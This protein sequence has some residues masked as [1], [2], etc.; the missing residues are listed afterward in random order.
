M[1]YRRNVDR[2]IDELRQERFHSLVFSPLSQALLTNKYL[3]G[4]PADSRAAGPEQIYFN[5]HDISAPMLTKVEALNEIALARGKTLAQM[6]I[7]WVLYNEV[8]NSATIGAS[9]PVQIDR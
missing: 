9:R 7:A 3:H 1:L 8:V 4:V 2:I 5:E 6:A